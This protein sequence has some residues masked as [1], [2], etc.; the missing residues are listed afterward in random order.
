[1]AYTPTPSAD[2]YRTVRV[3]FDAMPTY[4]TGNLTTQRDCNIVNFFYD[5]ISQE[6][7]T[8]EVF[9]KKR[10]GLTASGY[11]MTKD[12]TSDVLR[13]YYYDSV[14]N[15]FYWAVNDN[16]YRCSP[17][18]GT[19]IRTV[20]TM[21]TTTGYVG[22]CEFLQASTGTRFILFSDGVDLFIDNFATTTCTEV[23]DGDM[24]SPHVPQPVALDG[25]VFLAAA[26]TG[27]IYNCDNDD[28]T[29]WTAGDFVSTEMTGDY[30]LM[31]AQNRNYLVA[32]GQNSLEM[33][34]D[35]AITSGSPMKRADAGFRNVGYVTGLCQISN[36]LY[37]VGQDQGKNTGIYRIDGF[38]VEKISDEIVDRTLQTIT[39]TDNVKGQINLARP[40]Y[41]VSSDGHSFYCVVASQTTWVYDVDENKWYEWKGSDGTGLKLEGSWAMINGSQY[42]AI[43][44]Q[45]YISHM[46][47][48]LY[49]DFASNYTCSYTTERIDQDSYNWKVAN[50]L[51]LLADEHAATGSST[52]TIAWSDDDWVNTSA[53]RTVN[54]FRNAAKL[55]KLGR[56][57]TRSYRFSYA[58]NYPLR[59]RGMELELNIGTH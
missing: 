31:L 49:Q 5:R 11:N 2:T 44:G 35:A 42:V 54:L 51:T 18:D 22:F 20:D 58:D 19:A 14:A 41:S 23:S 40:G 10:P 13:G 17:D 12:A 6:N 7:K 50:R 57:R 3:G 24:P 16:V 32:F 48:S 15:A 28:P 56:F 26:D 29:A 55:Y 34:W 1:M 45:T 37:F 33:F 27:D 46:S 30:V 9:L 4:R 52:I 36:I 53:S 21:T 39:A 59:L 8:R 47:P 38:K 43:G 25:Y